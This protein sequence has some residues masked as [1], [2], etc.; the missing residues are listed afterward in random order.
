M[1]IIN[2]DI[3]EWIFTIIICL[4]IVTNMIP[5]EYKYFQWFIFNKDTFQ[6]EL[7]ETNDLLMRLN[8]HILS[9]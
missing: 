8:Q 1:E 6:G 2:N 7:G 9:K 3:N 4:N 5:Q